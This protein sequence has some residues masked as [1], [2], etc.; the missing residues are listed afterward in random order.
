MII[1][2]KLFVPKTRGKLIVRSHLNQRLNEGLYRKLTI[3][4]APAGYGK[5]TLL[6]EWVTTIDAH[7]GW[8]SLDE[9]DNNPA[10][11]WAHTIGALKR[12]NP[13]FREKVER[14]SIEIDLY[15]NT[16]IFK[17]IN[18]LHQFSEQTVLVWDD[19]HVIKDPS[20]LD[21]LSYLLERIPA[22][23]HFYIAT[24][25]QPI[26]P[27]SR[28]RVE[29]NLVELVADDL[30]FDIEETKAYF[31][32]CTEL[33]FNNIELLDIFQ[34]TEGWAAGMRMAALSIDNK[35][36]GTKVALDMSGKQRHVADYFFEE[37]LSKQ[38]KDVQQFLMKTSILERMNASLCKAVTNEM[39]A[40]IILQQLE[41]ENLF[42]V[43]LD[44]GRE[45]FRYHHLF[46]EFLSMQLQLSEPEQ[47]KSL[48][49]AAG[50]WFEENGFQQE[51]LEHYLSSGHYERALRLLER[52]LPLMPNYEWTVLHRWLNRI[53]DSELFNK[54]TFFLMNIAS[55]YLS[56]HIFEATEKY[57][58]VIDKLEKHPNLL[59]QKDKQHYGAGLDFLV[60]FRSFLEKD[61][62]SFI[63][64]AKRY[65]EQDPDGG[66]LPEFGIERDG[67]HPIWDIYLTCERE[68]LYEAEETL[69]MLVKMWE[70]TRHTL[71]LAHLCLDYGLLLYERNRLDE[72]EQYIQKALM[73]G[74]ECDNLNF[75]VKASLML[76]QIAVC[77]NRKH[78]SDQILHQLIMDVDQRKIPRLAKEIKLFQIRDMLK[79]GDFT[80][81]MK[82]AN[83]NGFSVSDEI[84]VAMIEEYE[85]FARVLGMQGKKTEAINL[86]N[87]LLTLAEKE[88]KPRHV[89]RLTILKSLLFAQQNQMFESFQALENVLSGAISNG[90]FR[91]FLDEG[92]HLEQLLKRY[93]QGIRNHYIKRSKHVDLNGVKRLLERMEIENL[94]KTS[95]N[96]KVKV[97]LSDNWLTNQ[98][99]KVL[100][101]M[102]KGLSN[103][104]IAEE[105]EVSL[106]TVK[107]HINHLYRKLGVRNRMSAIKKAQEMNL[108]SD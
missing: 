58:W 20:I 21:G 11:F 75:V 37:V 62:E 15:G 13:S 98:Q 96:F 72:A 105:L 32:Q 60:A 95:E 86:I 40:F 68:N 3:I 24:R 14:H 57:W 31:N 49:E 22:H 38:P 48:H 9:S 92:I 82:W 63:E 59:S 77:S 7:I 56:G 70:K 91:I 94:V 87:R 88:R 53:P 35:L 52:M 41:R 12:A 107:T 19:F 25:N 17:L 93:V 45:W 89:V 4:T 33:T 102:H 101:L 29:G 90:F 2:T 73:I 69:R 30:R 46:Q 55:L 74:K 99:M 34:R 65:L 106:S 81:V 108:L 27:I 85:L 79:H 80:T 54:P 23:V 10:Q 43:S 47:M 66:F 61:F 83:E 39:N 28:L 97:N 6:S 1:E 42:L 76:A 51:A 64:Y 103:K 16:H 100:K 18:L 84:S 5:S 71:F 26:L 44:K 78:N 36:N 104:E 50:R 8:I 67:Y